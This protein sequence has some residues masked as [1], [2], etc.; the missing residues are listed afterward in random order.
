MADSPTEEIF[1]ESEAQAGEGYGCQCGFKCNSLADLRR[2]FLREPRN[3]PPG[4]HKSLGR[5]NLQTGEKTLGTWTE[6]TPEQK[7]TSAY[8][9]RRAPPVEPLKLT[10]NLAS[11]QQ[12]KWVP[13][14]FTTDYTPIMRAG[15]AAT[16]RLWNWPEDMPLDRWMDL[17]V[18]SWFKDRGVTL[19]AFVID[20]EAF[21]KINAQREGVNAGVAVTTG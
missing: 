21:K 12:I 1:P 14:V 13:R 6:R 16:A 15:R 17:I 18:Q 10:D 8:S 2:H 3:D 11:A 9:V 4:T 19:A 20:E 5:I 7:R